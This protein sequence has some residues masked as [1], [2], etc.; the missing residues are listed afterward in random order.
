MK[1]CKK[2]DTILETNISPQKG[3]FEDD[4]PF[5]TVG[6]VSSLEGIYHINWLAGFL[7]STVSLTRNPLK[8]FGSAAAKA[9][10]ADP[11]KPLDGPKSK[12]LHD[13]ILGG[14]LGGCYPEN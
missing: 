12:D 1:P 3:T 8:V 6:Y 9:P 7:Q 13:G 4:F 10:R 5:P 11:A 2:W 14:K